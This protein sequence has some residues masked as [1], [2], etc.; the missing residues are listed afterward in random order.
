MKI[1]LQSHLC[2]WQDPGQAS[3]GPWESVR[4][5]RHRG[6]ADEPDLGQV[7]TQQG[8]RVTLAHQGR[9]ESGSLIALALKLVFR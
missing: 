4:A 3:Q 8:A 6:R 5:A 7:P 2:P 9:S 1:F